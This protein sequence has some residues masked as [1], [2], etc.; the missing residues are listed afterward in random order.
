MQEFE[1]NRNST[2]DR[3]Q[4]VPGGT[5]DAPVAIVEPSL[6]DL[7]TA[8]DLP[9]VI[10][11]GS[12]SDTVAAYVRR[13]WSPFALDAQIS[14]ALTCI[15]GVLS[16]LAFVAAISSR[17]VEGYGS[18]A[19]ESDGSPQLIVDVRTA[20]WT[21]FAML[22]GVGRTLARRM[23][24]ARDAAGNDLRPETFEAVRGVGPKTW[25]RIE[26]YLK[27]PER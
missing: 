16:L 19:I 17:S 18:V 5:V 22:P 10:D 27:F 25:R 2:A 23:V 13:R 4:T 15:V 6:A 24:E 21:D 12:A 3:E 1:A 11:A 20:E 14:T 9:A 8:T 26:P 7:A